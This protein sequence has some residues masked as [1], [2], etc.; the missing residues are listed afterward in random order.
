MVRD[1]LK[2]EAPVKKP[3]LE[4]P[5]RPIEG[6]ACKRSEVSGARLWGWIEATFG[7]PEQF[8]RRMFIGNSC[9]L[10]FMEE[11]G[12]NRTPDKLAAAEKLELFEICDRALR[13]TVECLEP[14]LVV[15]VGTFAEA[16][17]QA[18]L[19]GMDVRIGRI[20]H[21]SPASPSAN[22]GWAKTVTKQLAELGV[23]L[24]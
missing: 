21:P 18:S 11:S 3:K 20:L 23:E 19:H 5:K 24:P 14:K 12:R 7:S 16:R 8:A 22:N 1:W 2:I 9:P 6:F 10:V 4:H 13:F 15:G 17:A